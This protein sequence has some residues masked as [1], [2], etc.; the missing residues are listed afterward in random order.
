MNELINV[1]PKHGAISDHN[2]KKIRYL[3]KILNLIDPEKMDEAHV[4]KINHLIEKVNNC[5]QQDLDTHLVK[6]IYE[7]KYLIE[8]QLQHVL[9]KRKRAQLITRFTW[10]VL[11]IVLTLAAVWILKNDYLLLIIEPLAVI[12]F[13]TL[14][15]WAEK[16][17]LKLLQLS[18]I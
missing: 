2:K 17:P 14:L 6:V 10:S 7:V 18:R 1:E 13:I 11:A 15:E 4:L 8:K 16:R 5:P 9:L 12:L 3:L